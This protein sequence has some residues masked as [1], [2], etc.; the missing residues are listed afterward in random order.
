MCSFGNT[1]YVLTLIFMCCHFLV[2]HNLDCRIFYMFIQN[3]YLGKITSKNNCTQK[4][5]SVESLKA[6]H[7]MYIS[8]LLTTSSEQTMHAAKELI[9]TTMAKAKLFKLSNRR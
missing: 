7:Q 8:L 5:I 9:S 2:F 4:I 1:R 6:S 3:N